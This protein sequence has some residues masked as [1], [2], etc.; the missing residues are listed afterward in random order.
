MRLFFLTLSF[1]LRTKI[2]YGCIL[3]NRIL[4]SI[5][6][7]F[8]GVEISSVLSNIL[9]R[10]MPQNLQLCNNTFFVCVKETNR[11]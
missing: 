10:I 6:R 7:D 11:S 4:G 9:L 1:P 2:L 3:E 8:H 5:Q